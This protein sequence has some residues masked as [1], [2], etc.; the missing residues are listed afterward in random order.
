M[1]PHPTRAATVRERSGA[2]LFGPFSRSLTV[3][4]LAGLLIGCG[5]KEEPAVP[6][7]P[8]ATADASPT[9]PPADAGTTA[10]APISTVAHEEVAPGEPAGETLADRLPGTYTRESYGTRTLVVR[11]DGTATMTVDVDSLYQWIAGAARIVVQIDWTLT[12]EAD[13]APPSVHFSSVSG[14]PKA[15]FE[16]MSE[17]F[18]SERDWQIESADD[19]GLVFYNPE[20]DDTEI[21]TRVPEE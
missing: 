20:E 5:A 8:A 15:A 3:A 13:N 19:A 6:V 17:K 12:E 4:A 11:P 7:A 21:W 18:G 9:A 2:R 1:P 10:A 16:S 14:T